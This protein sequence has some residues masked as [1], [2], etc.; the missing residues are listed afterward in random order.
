ME[1]LICISVRHHS[2]LHEKLAVLKSVPSI[3]DSHFSFHFLLFSSCDVFVWI[4]SSF[5][6][7]PVL[8]WLRYAGCSMSS[9]SESINRLSPG[10]S[11]RF[12]LYLYSGTVLF[13]GSVTFTVSC[14]HSRFV[15]YIK[16]QCWV[17]W[18]GLPGSDTVW[19]TST[20]GT[21]FSCLV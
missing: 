14:C 10:C 20:A 12:H 17:R 4:C 6:H 2:V 13:I 16:L 8:G 5:C 21:L 9:V 18:W 7:L 3:R 15:H 1:L 11:P 19:W